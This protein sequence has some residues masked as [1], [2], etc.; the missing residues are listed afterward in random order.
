MAPWNVGIYKKESNYEFIGGGSIIAPN[1]VI[2][3]N[4]FVQRI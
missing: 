1:L 3:G 2:S 4:I